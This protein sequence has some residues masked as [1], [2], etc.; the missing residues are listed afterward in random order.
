MNNLQL[1]H[2]MLKQICQWFPEERATRQRN[3]AL[4]VI[5]LYL[6]GSVHLAHVVRRLPLSGQDLSLVNR[7]RRFLDNPRVDV[8]A[9]YRPVAALLLGRLAGQSVWLVIDGTKV[10]FGHH[11]LMVGVLYHGRTLPVAW[12]VHPGSRGCTKAAKQIALLERVLTVLPPT[13]PV[14]LLGDAEFGTVPLLRWLKGQHWDFVIRSKG[15]HMVSWPD[16]PWVKLAALAL[17]PGE[18]RCIGWVQFT[19]KHQ[20]ADLWLVMH[21]AAGEDEPWY[22]LSTQP[23]SARRVINTYKR[24]MWIE[25]MF[26]D[27]KG[28]GFDLE[29]THLRDPD[30][31]SRLV[32][33]VCM[34]FVWLIA[35][36]SWVVKRGLR[37]RVDC[38]SRR[39]KSYFRI[40]WDWVARCLRLDDPVPIRFVPYF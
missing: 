13:S 32:W 15:C 36:G 38:K 31:I 16:Q 9:W 39:D 40:G 22:L 28:H 5:G 23:L 33:G 10:G 29:T 17:Q 30:R 34:A 4:L 20:M 7:L 14:L 12:S 37:R 11:L 25:E 19:H 2:K 35:T 1:Y 3:G 24:R 26:G 18:T 27:L 21:W 8:W 6:S